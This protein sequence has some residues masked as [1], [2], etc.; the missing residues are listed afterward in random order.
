MDDHLTYFAQQGSTLTVGANQPLWLN[1]GPLAWVVLEGALDVF[2]VRAEQGRPVGARQHLFRAGRGLVVLGLAAAQCQDMLLL[3]VGVP[4]TKLSQMER[5]ALIA[6]GREETAGSMIDQWVQALLAACP[7]APPPRDLTLLEPTAKVDLTPEQAVMSAQGVVWLHPR[8]GSLR[9]FDQPEG[10]GSSLADWAPLGDGVWMT[11]DRET[12]LEAAST[13]G[14]ISRFPGLEPLDQF[15]DFILATLILRRG[16]TLQAQKEHLLLQEAQ[17]TQAI[18]RALG[19]LAQVLEDRQW[20]Q[21]ATAAG[22]PLVAACTAVADWLDIT[23]RVPSQ[24]LGGLDSLEALMRLARASRVRVR[25]VTLSSRW[26]EHDTGAFIAFAQNDGRPLAVVPD[27]PRTHK[28]IDPADRTARTVTEALARQLAPVAYVLYRPF[29]IKELGWWDTFKFGCKG[30]AGD[31]WTVLIMG[32]CGGLLGMVSPIV[33]GLIFDSIVPS[34]ERSQLMQMLVALVVVALVTTAFHLTRALAVLRVEGRM[35]SEIQSAVWDRLLSLPAP[36]FRG[37]TAGDLANRANGINAMRRILSGT[38]LNSLLTFVFSLFSFG[39]LFYYDWTLALIVTGVVLVAIIFTAVLGI[40]ELRFQRP[41]TDLQG[42][43]SGLVLQIISGINKLHVAGAE[44]RAFKS[45]ADVFGRQKRLAYKSRLIRNI[46]TTFNGGLPILGTGLI[47]Y[48]MVFNGHQLSTGGYMAF[49]TAFGNFLS[50]MLSM[51]MSFMSLLQIIPLYDR[52]KPILHSLPEFDENSTDPGPISGAV[53]IS[54]L[55]FRYSA[56][57]PLILRDV[58]INIQP[59]EFVALVGPSG[60]G[61]STLLRLL[62]GFEE[63]EAGAVYYDGQDLSELDKQAVRRQIGVVLQS[64]KLTPGDILTNIIGSANLTEEDAWEAAARSGLDA[65]IKAMPMGMHTVVSEG[66]GTLSGGQTQR[67]LIARAIVKKP[68][69]VFLD[70]ATSALDNRTQAI[71]T[72]SL[73][74]LK[75]TRIAIAHRL[76]TIQHADRIVV[77]RAGQVVETGTFDELMKLQGEFFALARRQMA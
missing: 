54:H 24:S 77:L 35:D 75:S 59:G 3:A 71:V 74:S 56:E 60:S 22:D 68:R 58:N 52:A 18:D 12:S 7:A 21:L 57:G 64:G 42:R 44:E 23:L 14:I 4:G 51:T 2:A 66:S 6:P 17:A 34:A 20:E 62:L 41:L 33:T 73:Q 27:S 1:Q 63:P 11:P 8:Q 45:W 61:K 25:P 40:W 29:P 67:L 31:F 48:W 47:F 19:G 30:L 32:I 43:I 65:D 53:E 9:L 39:L 26:W 76:S 49:S 16:Q 38:I 50:A 5:A 70:E 36:F 72:E 69:I 28:L 10:P 13:Q 55:N 37:Y 15:H 46:L